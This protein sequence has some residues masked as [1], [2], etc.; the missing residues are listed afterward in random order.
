M[1]ATVEEISEEQI[2]TQLQSVADRY[3]AGYLTLYK[4][5]TDPDLVYCC[6]WDL[7]GDI[8]GDDWAQRKALQAADTLLWL[9]GVY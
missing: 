8:A 7:I 9:T 5:R 3:P 4:A 6:S 2:H 1:G